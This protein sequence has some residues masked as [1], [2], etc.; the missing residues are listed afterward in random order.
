MITQIDRRTNGQYDDDYLDLDKYQPIQRRQVHE[1]PV[2]SQMART[3][4]RMRS[5][6]R[7][8]VHRKA[9]P[10]NGSNRRGRGK[11]AHSWS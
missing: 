1:Y 6:A 5:R 11:F 7:S 2:A 4:A 8:A 3:R 9:Q 10:F